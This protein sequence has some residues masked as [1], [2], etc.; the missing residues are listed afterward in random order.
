M[1]PVGIE[2]TMASQISRRPH[3]DG[4][5]HGSRMRNRDDTIEAISDR[6]KKRT[7]TSVPRWSSRSNASS[8]SRIPKRRWA[9]SRCAE[10]LTG[11][12]SVAPW[13]SPRRIDWRKVTG[14][15][16]RA[17]RL[18][19]ALHG[20]LHHPADPAYG[21]LVPPFEPQ[22]EHRLG[23]GGPDKPPPGVEEGPDPVDV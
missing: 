17:D 4:A 11:R 3:P 18:P 8:G 9:R 12:N 7:A 20:F 5:A 2:A 14:R 16:S 15:R 22:H 19:G 1:T 23:I 21:R 6:R 13:S 10:L